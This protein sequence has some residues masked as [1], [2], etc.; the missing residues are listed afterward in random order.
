M[1]KNIYYLQTRDGRSYRQASQNEVN[2][3]IEN[4]KAEW[5]GTDGDEDSDTVTHYADWRTE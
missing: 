1:T 4:G 5:A 3:L 2:V